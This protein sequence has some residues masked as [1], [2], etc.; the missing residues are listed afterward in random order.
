MGSVLTKDVVFVLLA[1]FS[2]FASFNLLIPT[3]PVYI[4]FLGGSELVVGLLGGL[5]TFGA[6]LTRPS[7]AR[8][9]D[10]IGR[11][12]LLLLSGFFSVT[13]PLLYLV[14]E[15][16]WFLTLARLYHS[17]C[18]GGFITAGQTLLADLAPSN[19]RGTIM[20]MFGLM[21]GLSLAMF[22]AIGFAIIEHLGFT[23]LFM[24]GSVMGLAI[25]VVGLFVKEPEASPVRTGD[26]PTEKLPLRGPILL[27]CAAAASVTAIMGGVNAFLPLYGMTLEISNVGLYFT[28]FAVFHMV[29]GV[30]AGDLSD[31]FGRLRV[32]MPAF[33][34]AASGMVVLPFAGGYGLFLLS[35]ALVGAGVASVGAVMLSHVMDRV[36]SKQRSQ[37]V[38]YY[39]NAFDIGLSAGAMAL[40]RVAGLSFT[41]LWL[42][43]GGSALTGFAMTYMQKRSMG[44]PR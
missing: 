8:L 42:I 28:T 43:L 20:G 9:S 23:W 29:G 31:K 27:S 26:R 3:F 35:A 44:K 18:L 24:I 15:A 14:S 6:V 2:F 5:M 16:F 19:R 38:S 13:G 21:G 25:I 17:M 33:L 36:T 39:N 41:A 7:L 4:S 22:P 34:L 11:K 1:T 30:T 32:A 10:R 40:G 12:N 37:V